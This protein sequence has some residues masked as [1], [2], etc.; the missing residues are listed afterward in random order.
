M[1]HFSELSSILNNLLHWHKT[2]VD[3]L[4]GIVL[5]LLAV[6]TVNLRE[7]ALAFS[8][9]SS[10]NARYKRIKG[11]FRSIRFDYTVLAK[12]LFYLFHQPDK[13]SYLTIDRTNWF[14]GKLKINVMTLAIAYEGIAIPLFWCL[15]PK[16]GN[17]TASEHWRL[18]ERFIKV[19][20]KSCIA[21]ILGDREFASGKLFTLLNKHDIPFY[22]RIKEGAY[23]QAK[24][25]KIF[26][27]KEIFK[28]LN[29]KEQ[30]IY[31]MKTTLYGAAVYLAGAR[32]EKGELMIV[33][34][35]Q[36]PQNAI[37]IYLRRWEIENLFQSLKSRGFQFERTHLVHLERIEK[38]V[39]VLAIAFAW[40]HKV[41]EWRAL[42][43]PIVFNRYQDGLRPQYS[44]FSYGLCM[45]RDILLQGGRMLKKLKNC[46]KL[47]ILPSNIIK[48]ITS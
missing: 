24:K 35:N 31:G 11:F 13:P 30:S 12:W 16:A 39:A 4:A 9:K 10:Y 38:L 27:A 45:L 34:T 8:S 2:R 46:L 41:G 21:G 18:I 17:A 37:S 44:Y 22:I 42:K 26:K 43:K 5:G 20:G 19:F 40:A 29:C 25:Q 7:I 6:R 3:C 23:I 47:L 14:W 36:K 28:N 48:E 32:S 15:L 33:A 1:I